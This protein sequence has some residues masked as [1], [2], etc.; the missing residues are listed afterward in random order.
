MEVTNYSGSMTI[1]LNIKVNK[2]FFEDLEL[3]ETAK[4]YNI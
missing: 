3:E 4:K 1:E 2:Q